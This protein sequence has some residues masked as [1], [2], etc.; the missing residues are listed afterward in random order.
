MKPDAEK[1]PQS[2]KLK[3]I[4]LAAFLGAAAA[5][6]G[7]FAFCVYHGHTHLHEDWCACCKYGALVTAA[8]SHPIVIIGALAGICVLSIVYLIRLLYKK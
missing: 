6:S 1:E 3:Y 5:L 8:F 4:V 7:V 2:K